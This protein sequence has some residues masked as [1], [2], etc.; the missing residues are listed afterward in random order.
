VGRAGRQLRAAGGGSGAEGEALHLHGGGAGGWC[1]VV[2]RRAAADGVGRG[3]VKCV[4]VPGECGRRSRADNGHRLGVPRP[5]KPRRTPENHRFILFVIHCCVN[6]APR[7]VCGA[8]EIF[9]FILA[10]SSVC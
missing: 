3:F 8:C 10:D 5:G 2:P 6:L 7:R 9:V 4:R 1:G